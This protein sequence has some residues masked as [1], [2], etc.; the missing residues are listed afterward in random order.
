[1]KT[2]DLIVTGGGLSGVAT[3]IAAA[4]GGMKVLL[5]EKTNALG[6]AAATMLVMPFML[7]ETKMPDGTIR[8]LSLGIFKEILE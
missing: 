6:G 5:C 2:Y 8:E 7:N 4:R 3:A 1:M